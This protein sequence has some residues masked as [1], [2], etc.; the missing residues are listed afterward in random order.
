HHGDRTGAVNVGNEITFKSSIL[1][2]KTGTI[3]AGNEILKPQ[4]DK[5]ALMPLLRGYLTV[6]AVHQGKRYLGGTHGLLILDDPKATLAE[7]WPT[8]AL[9]KVPTQKQRWQAEAKDRNVTVRSAA[10]LAKLL[11]EANPLL[12]IKAMEA[13]ANALNEEYLAALT[14]ASRDEQVA[15]RRLA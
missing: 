3:A 7:P 4:K 15:V 8:L 10:D 13:L 14:K 1:D 2:L 11:E 5:R 12:R 6:D 9:E